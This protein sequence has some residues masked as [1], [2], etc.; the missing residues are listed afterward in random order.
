[1]N[2]THSVDATILRAVQT[3]ALD[4]GYTGMY[5]HDDFMLPL[6]AF[7]GVR[8][9]IKQQMELVREANPYQTAMED[10]AANHNRPVQ[11]PKLIIGDAPNHI[12][13]SEH[14]LMP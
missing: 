9:V 11:I 12:A 10:I 7:K 5:K 2:I 1:M 4:N 8:E 14:F 3:Y 13:D 6:N